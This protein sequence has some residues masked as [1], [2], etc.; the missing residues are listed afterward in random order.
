MLDPALNRI[1]SNVEHVHLIAVCGTAMGALACMLKDRGMTVTGSDQKVY[2]PMSDFL[3]QRGIAVQEGFDVGRF[4]R[5]PDLVVVG[6]AVRRDNPE[7]SALAQQGIAYCSMPQ[8]IN[9]FAAAGKLQVVVAGTHGKTT[10]SSLIAWILHHAGHDPSFL[11]GGILRNFDCNYRTGDGNSIVLEGDE[12]DTAFFDKGAKFFH[13]R[14]KVAVLTGVEFDHADIFTD[15]GHVRATFRRFVGQLPPDGLLVAWDGDATLD[16]LVAGSPARVMRYGRS[17]TADWRIDAVVVR[18]PWTHF[19]LI[20]RGRLWGRFCSPLMGD[21][22]LAN[23]AAAL[24]VVERL[25]VDAHQA[26]AGLEAFAGVRRRQEVRGVAGGVTVMDDFAHHPTAVR[27]TIAAVRP[28][29]PAGRLIAVFEPRTNTSMR[30][31]FQDVYPASFDGADLVLVRRPSAIEK[32]P[33]AERFSSPRLVS[34]LKSRGLAAMHFDTTEGI[35]DFLTDHCRPGDLVL[36][37]SNGG[38]D[39]IHRRLLTALAGRSASTEG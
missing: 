27:E 15:V 16:E 18:P 4:V 11:I 25:G 1:D 39:D 34:D 31:V 21:H 23:T 38:F 17:E 33:E 5:R 10:T 7:V 22:N 26:A 30:R 32:V 12:Y 2:P 9:H 29:F 3:R 6:N 28:H 37:M 8:A 24:A 35:I 36:I 20:C 19:D 14:P 13:Y